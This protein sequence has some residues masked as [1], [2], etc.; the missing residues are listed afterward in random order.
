MADVVLAWTVKLL[1]S[2]SSDTIDPSTGKAEFS[3]LQNARH[4]AGDGNYYQHSEKLYGH[5][6]GDFDDSPAASAASADQEGVEDDAEETKML[7]KNSKYIT[8]EGL[9]LEEILEGHIK[10]ANAHRCD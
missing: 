1:V 4:L 5:E 6:E 10:P 2:N 7:Q 9:L 8:E 3:P